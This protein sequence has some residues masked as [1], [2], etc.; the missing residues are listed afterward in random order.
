M[1]PLLFLIL[2]VF[3]A[4]NALAAAR[5]DISVVGEIT[6]LTCKVALGGNM[7]VTLPAQKITALTKKYDTAGKTPFTIS[8][9]GCSDVASFSFENDQATVNAEGRLVNTAVAGAKNIELQ[10]LN[11]SGATV[12]LVGVKGQQNISESV[13]VKPDTESFNFSVQYF[14]LGAA[15]AG[16]VKSSLTFLVEFN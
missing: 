15:V 12:D 7:T 4:G 3:A 6:S 13:S 9:A 10:I 5:V 8:I 14:S 11:E 1:W 2:L 16:S